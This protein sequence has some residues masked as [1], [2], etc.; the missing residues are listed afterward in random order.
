[1]IKKL[2]EA[3]SSKLLIESF[4]EFGKLKNI[5]APVIINIIEN[6]FRAVIKKHYTTDDNF[7][8]II[9]IE[10][11]DLE[12]WRNRTVVDDNSEDIWDSDAITISEAQKLSTEYEIDD[13]VSEEIKL[14]SFGRRI[15]QGIRQTLLQKTKEIEKDSLYYKYKDKIGQLIFSKVNHFTKY[16]ILLKDDEGNELVLPKTEQIPG[17]FFKKNET[18][19]GIIHSV[20][21]INNKPRIVVSRSSPV[22]IERLFEEEVNEIY[23]GDVTIEKIARIAGVKTKV[24]VKTNSEYADA[25][26]VCVGAKGYHIRNILNEFADERID[27][28]NYTSNVELMVSRLLNPAKVG[29]VIINKTNNIKSASVYIKA[30]QIALAMGKNKVNLKL[31]SQILGMEINL[32]NEN[33]NVVESE[34]DVLLDDFSNDIEQ[35]MIDELKNIGLDTA[36]HVLAVDKE[37]LLRRTDLE[38]EMIENIFEIL[39]EEFK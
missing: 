20:E 39:I 26:S 19:K 22:F 29:N 16:E 12:I 33:I 38:L 31:A 37:D 5:E 35:W 36:R 8:I 6:I 30:D 2:T 4:A 17:E 9:N 11:G 18:V 21:I 7:D 1:M 28:V 25:V 27:M 13:V 34:D 10:R 3:D 32:Y 24:V 15:I 23:S 14:E